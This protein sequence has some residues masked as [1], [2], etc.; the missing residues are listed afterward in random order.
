M[1]LDPNV[2]SQFPTGVNCGGQVLDF[3]H[4][5][6]PKEDQILS[7]HQR[8]PKFVSQGVIPSLPITVPD[9]GTGV[10]NIPQNGVIFGNT[11]S[12]IGTVPVNAT[13]TRKFLEQ[14]SSAAPVFTTLISSDI[15]NNGASTTGNAGGLSTVK[16]NATQTTSNTNQVFANGPSGTI[17]MFAALAGREV[18]SFYLVNTFIAATS[19]VFLQVRGSDMNGIP[20]IVSTF[21]PTTNLILIKIYNPS[22]LPQTAPTQID[23]LVN[24]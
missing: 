5:E 7:I 13:A 10:I 21:Q 23:Y 6:F 22:S 8:R 3:S 15:P 4:T 14:V 17:T 18:A 2:P 12:P 9:G 20:P 24:Q 1:N 11:T 19:K 16:A